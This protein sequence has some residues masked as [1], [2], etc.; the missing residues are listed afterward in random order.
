MS[1]ILKGILKLKDFKKIITRYNVFGPLSL[2]QAET[3]MARKI[4]NHLEELRIENC[5][6]EN[7]ITTNLVEVINQKCYLKKLGLVSANIT[8]EAFKN[9]CIFVET[10]PYLNDLD[11]SWNHI[12]PQDFANLLRI[13]STNQQLKYLNLSHNSI[14]GDVPPTDF[15][16]EK[17]KKRA[18]KRI[19]KPQEFDVFD[20]EKDQLAIFGEEL[21]NLSKNEKIGIENLC[22][23]IRRNRELIHVDISYAGL[24]EIQLWYFGRTLR[25]AKSI[26]SLH[27]SGNRTYNKESITP[28][29]KKYL[30]ERVHGVA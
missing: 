9:L 13:L 18:V 16:V 22:K 28:T 10:A 1:A 17:K 7:K 25:R 29:L 20:E 2:A 3:L 15:S 14:L 6:I 30:V 8:V 27:L 12:R 11:L 5:K 19:A 24:S 23:F 26:R 21:N 4:P